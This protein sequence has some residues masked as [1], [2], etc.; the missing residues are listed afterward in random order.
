[1]PAPPVYI[2]DSIEK[3][4]RPDG[5]KPRSRLPAGKGGDTLEML[6]KNFTLDHSTYS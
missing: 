5:G 2:F 3:P 1:L 6:S 4:A